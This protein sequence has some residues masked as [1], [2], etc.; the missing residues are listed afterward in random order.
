MNTDIKAAYSAALRMLTRREHCEA[1]VRNKLRQRGFDE[2]A[3]D[4]AIEELKQYGYLSDL[5]YAGAFLRYRMQRGEAPW[6]AAAKAAQKGVD[7]TALQ[8]AL[9]E[10]EAS[11]DADKACRELLHSR[12]PGG[13]RRN[14]ERVWQRHARFLRNHG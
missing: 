13:L 14:S 9:E 5:R 11:F 10:A 8:T 2:I 4:S 12:D 7:E 6:M 1:E 3:A